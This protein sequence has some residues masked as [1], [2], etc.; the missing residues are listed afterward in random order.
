MLPKS[1]SRAT[2]R[3]ESH[4]RQAYEYQCNGLDRA[5]PD[6]HRDC[7]NAHPGALNAAAAG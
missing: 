2:D 5:V 7:P 1:S 6:E 3:S 4:C